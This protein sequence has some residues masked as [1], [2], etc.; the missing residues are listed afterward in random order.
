MGDNLGLAKQMMGLPQAPLKKQRNENADNDPISEQQ[1]MEA[2]LPFAM[3]VDAKPD[4]ARQFPR[5]DAVKLD[6]RPDAKLDAVR[7]D[8][9]PDAMK[10]DA[11]KPDAMKPDNEQKNMGIE[12]D[13]KIFDIMKSTLFQSSVVIIV[14]IIL[15]IIVLLIMYFVWRIKKQKLQTI[16]LHTNTIQLNSPTVP[17]IVT[18]DKMVLVNAGQEFSFTFWIYLAGNYSNT[19]KHKPILIRGKTGNTYVD[20]NTNPIVFLDKG[21][22]V[23]YVA[24]AT[25]QVTSGTSITLD[26]VLAKNSG[27]IVAKIDYVPLQRWVNIALCVRD[28]YGYLFMD[29]DLHTVTSVNDIASTVRP[30]IKGV[31]GDLQIGDK[32]NNTPGFISYTSFCNYALTSKDIKSIYDNGPYERTLISFMGLGNYGLRSPIYKLD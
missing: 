29:G 19:V 1:N 23:L 17:Y 11:M 27:F 10:P 5:Q 28:N 21:T 25:N 8:A 20:F 7:L 15:I 2:R 13:Q 6:I 18:S 4:N 31:N 22:N 32:Y 12:F 26:E 16:V 24:F 3:K 14:I 30:I 9:K